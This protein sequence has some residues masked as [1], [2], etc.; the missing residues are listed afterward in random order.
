MDCDWLWRHIDVVV[1]M[2][3]HHQHHYRR[4]SVVQRCAT[5]Q[6]CVSRLQIK[7]RPKGWKIKAADQNQCRRPSWGPKGQKWR[8][9]A[10]TAAKIKRIGSIATCLCVYYINFTFVS[11]WTAIGWLTTELRGH[12]AAPWREAT[13]RDVTILYFFL[14]PLQFTLFSGAFYRDKTRRMTSYRRRHHGDA[15]SASSALYIEV[16]GQ[17]EARRAER[18][19][20]KSI[21]W[22]RSSGQGA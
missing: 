8:L 10:D 18:R 4:C 17:V 13:K 11:V 15:S 9:Q 16:A 21:R 22:R 3:T 1:T 19:N 7:I 12:A 14:S 5:L 20:R 6:R 2:V